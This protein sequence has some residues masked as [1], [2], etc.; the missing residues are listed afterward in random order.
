MINQTPSGSTWV[1]SYFVTQRLVV[2]HGSPCGRWYMMYMVYRCFCG[3]TSH[4]NLYHGYRN[5]M[6]SLLCN[7]LMTIPLNVAIQLQSNLLTMA[8]I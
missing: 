4:G 6:K 5:P 8:Q 1:N 7:G 3:H 2:S